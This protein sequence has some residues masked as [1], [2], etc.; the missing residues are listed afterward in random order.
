[1]P[2]KI[3][4]NIGEACKILGLSRRTFALIQ[5][6]IPS[7]DMGTGKLYYTKDA[8]LEWAKAKQGEAK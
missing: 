1:M 8:L 6:Q 7:V 4:Y 2:E 3:L 5:S